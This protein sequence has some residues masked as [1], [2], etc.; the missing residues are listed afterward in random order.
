MKR[1]QAPSQQASSSEAKR[2]PQTQYEP[3]INPNWKPTPTWN[4]ISSLEL[5]ELPVQEPLSPQHKEDKEELPPWLD[6]DETDPDLDKTNLE[7]AD[8][9]G[10]HGLVLFSDRTKRE[11]IEINREKIARE[12]ARAGP[13]KKLVIRERCY[14]LEFPK[15]PVPFFLHIDHEDYFLQ[16]VTPHPDHGR[17]LQ[18]GFDDYEEVN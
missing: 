1:E 15:A 11:Q 2:A 16:Y 12:N 5:P 14:T 3:V 13:V 18:L 9:K 6:L 10:P 17:F 8:E 4:G 7:Q